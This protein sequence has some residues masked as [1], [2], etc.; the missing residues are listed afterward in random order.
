MRRALAALCACALFAAPAHA[1]KRSVNAGGL[2]TF[3]SQRGHSYM[4]DGKGTPD[5]P[6]T[7]AFDAIRRSFLTWSGASCSD[8]AFPDLGISEN[9]AD[10]RTGYVPGGFNRNLVF[11]RTA[12][13]A[14]GAVPAGDACLSEGGCGN[15]YDCWEKA[16][17]VIATTTTTSNRFTGQIADSDIEVN[18]APGPDG[19]KFTFTAIDGPPCLD[20]NQTNCVRIDIRNTI[21]HEAG[22]SVGL[23]HSTDPTATMYATAPEGETAKRFLHPDDELA[24]CAIY[25]KGAPVV[26]CLGDPLTLTQ[27]GA[28]DGGGCGC[29]TGGGAGPGLQGLLLAGLVGLVSRQRRAAQVAT[30]ARRSSRAAKSCVAIPTT[31]MAGAQA[32]GEPR[33]R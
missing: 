19:L 6:P 21:T 20:T 7:L 23:D 33:S 17:G 14:G 9:P 15:K 26:T 25:P 18:D 29:S 1:Y 4:I 11:F 22:H 2:C 27:T 28:S 5:V 10:R 16:G 31:R 13:C 30:G 3:W 24:I 12:N 32:K 8:L